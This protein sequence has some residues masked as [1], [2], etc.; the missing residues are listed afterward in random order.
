M[1]TRRDAGDQEQRRGEKRG[2]ER[3]TVV[4][5]RMREEGRGDF[6]CL[7]VGAS[8]GVGV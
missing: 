2:E 7:S 6:T 5:M 1:T 4:K 8:V 3:T